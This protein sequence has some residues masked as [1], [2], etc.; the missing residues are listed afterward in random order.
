MGA[1]ERLNQGK[2]QLQPARPARGFFSCLNAKRSQPGS[3]GRAAGL[4]YN[5]YG[6]YPLPQLILK[7]ASHSEPRPTAS[8]QKDRRTAES[9][10]PEEFK[11]A[12]EASRV[13]EAR[14]RSAFG[15][16]PHGMALV[17][18]SGRFLQVNRFLCQ[19]LGYSEAELLELRF[20]DISHPDELEAGVVGLKQLLDGRAQLFEIE[21][22]YLHKERR[23]VWAHIR[24]NLLRDAAGKPLYFVS[25]IQDITERKQAEDA[26]RQSEERYYRLVELSHDGILI[27]C[28]GKLVFLNPAAAKILGA[29]FPEQLI[30]KQV[31]DLVHPDY[32]DAVEKRMKG[33]SEG[34]TFQPFLRQK[35]MK[36]DGAEVYVEAAGIPF[37]YKGQSAI[38]VI[39]RDVT[40]ITRAEEEKNR[41]FGEV[42]AAR[43]ELRSL[44]RRLVEVQELERR[45]IARELHDEIGQE[46]TALRLNIEQGA[47]AAG[48]A[49]HAS[50][51]EAQARVNKL[52]GLVRELSLDLRPT[53]LDD[54]G[55]L[56]A[57]LW[58]FDRYAALSGMKVQFK[59]FGVEG[60]RFSPE[61]ETAAYR[62]V[63]E[64]MTN[65]LRHSGGK[66]VN[67]TV[68]V[69]DQN[70]ALA[71]QIADDGV[72]FDVEASFQR[73]ESSGLSG[74]RERAALLGGR[75]MV[76]SVPRE[77]T[78]VTAELPLASNEERS[79][80]AP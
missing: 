18:P 56:P 35:L 80:Q 15:F 48:E 9:A 63:Q 61:I 65:V 47:A 75:F 41:L 52:L 27:H 31:L 55:L 3:S 79:S 74:M 44:S 68:W 39:L 36:L 30:N 77:G 8:S 2:D 57:L 50:C 32:R 59:H 40:E 53:M 10:G 37:V 1:L 20:Q 66:E 33:L 22:K 29:D 16:A 43:D 60:R 62:I 78:T 72:G 64:A 38:Q 12:E 58:Q 6:Q 42:A 45:R 5:K 34:A 28:Q 13:N 11:R 23:I 69:S 46:L 25:H 19:M 17:A 73:G 76:Q 54:L 14:F 71:I 67:V 26:L 21:K 24:A 49:A 51:Q 70:H 7:T 4:L